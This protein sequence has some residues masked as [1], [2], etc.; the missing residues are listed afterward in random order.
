MGKTRRTATEDKKRAVLDRKRSR[1][2][3]GVFRLAA[4]PHFTGTGFVGMSCNKSLM[5]VAM[6][7]F[8]GAEKDEGKMQ[9]DERRQMRT[10][11]MARV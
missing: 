7:R 1:Q 2:R 10:R 9:S 6:S 4:S 5:P 8:G 11:S 3:C